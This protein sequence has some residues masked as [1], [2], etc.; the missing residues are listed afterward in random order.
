ML[1]EGNLSLQERREKRYPASADVVVE[2]SV[3]GVAF[4][5]VQDMFALLPGLLCCRL[6]Q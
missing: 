6:F 2:Q 3:K 5:V 1:L 4:E